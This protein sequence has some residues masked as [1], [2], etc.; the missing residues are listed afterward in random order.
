MA[1]F[2]QVNGPPQRSKLLT[3]SLIGQLFLLAK[4][5]KRRIVISNTTN[6]E[7]YYSQMRLQMKLEGFFIKQQMSPFLAFCNGYER[8][9]GTLTDAITAECP[10][11][12]SDNSY[13]AQIVRNFQLGITFKAEDPDALASALRQIQDYR[14]ADRFEKAKLYLSNEAIAF[15]HL[16]IAGL[17]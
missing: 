5:Q 7:C 13:A 10:V 9:S 11:V 2:T 8:N 12:V 3:A 4:W 6:G 17:K 1:R 16:E 15:R 14:P